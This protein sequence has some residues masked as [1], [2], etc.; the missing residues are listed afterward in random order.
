MSQVIRIW[1]S[2]LIRVWS[3][4]SNP[5]LEGAEAGLNRLVTIGTRMLARVWNESTNP[6]LDWGNKPESGLTPT[7]SDLNGATLAKSGMSQ[8]ARIWIEPNSQ[9]LEPGLNLQ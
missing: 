3:D 7:S 9:H 5:Y 8:L 6:N 1:K 4:P 2:Q